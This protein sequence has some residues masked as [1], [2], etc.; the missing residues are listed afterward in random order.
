M[1]LSPQDLIDKKIVTYPVTIDIT[2][3]IQQNGL[4]V[5]CVSVFGFD[6][7]KWNVIGVNKSVKAE[8]QAEESMSLP[9]VGQNGW[10][11]EK[12]KA[13]TFDSSFQIEIPDGMCG[14]VIGRSTFNRQGILIRS[15]LFDSGFKGTIGGT[16]YCFNNVAI[17][18]GTRIGQFVMCEA[19]NASRYAGQY[20]GGSL[21]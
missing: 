16:I 13:F 10:M 20:Q 8:P 3:H 14:W 12:G 9:L 17:E 5:D 11:L 6:A 4:D 18:E 15:S 19:K 7:K 2:K 1:F 21:C